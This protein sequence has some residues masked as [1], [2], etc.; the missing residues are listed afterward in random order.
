[1]NILREP[2][3]PFVGYTYPEPLNSYIAR[4]EQQLGQRRLYATTPRKFSW[5]IWNFFSR[6]PSRHSPGR[7]WVTDVEDYKAVRLAEGIAQNT[8]YREI[9]F[10][11]TFFNWCINEAGLEMANPVIATRRVRVPRDLPEPLPGLEPEGLRLVAT[12]ET[13]S[14]VS[15]ASDR[16]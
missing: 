9:G 2:S 1:M 13:P 15:S 8:L 4:F 5:T 3:A 10:L 14:P 11:K 16:A 7:I 12:P 6:L